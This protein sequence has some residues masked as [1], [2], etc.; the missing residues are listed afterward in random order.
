MSVSQG[1]K[2]WEKYEVARQLKGRVDQIRTQY[3]EDL[4]SKQMVTRQ[5]AVALYFID[6]VTENKL[7]VGFFLLPS[8]FPSL[9]LSLCPSLT[10]SPPC[11]FVNPSLSLSFSLTH[12]SHFLSLSLSCSLNLSP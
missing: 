8:Y 6:K 2:D 3:Q 5:R 11:F 1:E 4:K 10:L 9:S 12:S 7:D